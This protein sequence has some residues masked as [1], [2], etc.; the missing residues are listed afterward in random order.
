MGCGGADA[1]AGSQQQP[2]AGSSGQ[3]H[4]AR[5]IGAVPLRAVLAA[6]GRPSTINNAMRVAARAIQGQRDTTRD[7]AMRTVPKR[8]IR[9]TTKA[10]VNP[11][12]AKTHVEANPGAGPLVRDP[13]SIASTIIVRFATHALQRC[14]ATLPPCRALRDSGCPG[15]AVGVLL[16]PF[17]PEEVTD[18]SRARHGDRSMIGMTF[19]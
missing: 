15:T 19:S 7:M 13:P 1:P 16:Q 9:N 2:P 14:M 5:F 6:A 10:L 18:F 17:L 4:P 8:I 3:Q 11:S 12:Y